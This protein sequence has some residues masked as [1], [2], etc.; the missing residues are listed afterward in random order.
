[1]QVS[2]QQKKLSKRRSI[3]DAGRWRGASRLKPLPQPEGWA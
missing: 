3:F 1:M 2:F